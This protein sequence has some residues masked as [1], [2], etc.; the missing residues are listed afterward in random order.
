MNTNAV[1][2]D[3]MQN[4]PK[5]MQFHYIRCT[6]VVVQF[7]DD[8]FCVLFCDAAMVVQYCEY[9]VFGKFCDAT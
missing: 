1:S 4:E 7:C 3:S 5:P 2:W 6:P 9:S 8:A